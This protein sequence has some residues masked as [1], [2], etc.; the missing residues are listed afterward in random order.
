MKKNLGQV[1]TDKWL[2]N[3]IL[4]F[5]G[6][7]DNH[8]LDKKIIEPSCGDGAFLLEIVK[9]YIDSALSKNWSIQQIKEGLENHIYA[10]EIDKKYYKE[11]ILKLNKLLEKYQIT[12]VKWNI[13]NE[14]ALKIHQ[15]NG[16]MDFV[17]G[18]PPYVRVHNLD[19]EVR[20]YI[21]D[22]YKLCNNG[23]IDLY[24][25]FYELG[26]NMLNERGKLCYIT[27]NSFMYNNSFSIFREH[28]RKEQFLSKLINFGS[29]KVFNVSTYTA[30]MLLDKTHK[31]NLFDY[32]CYENKCIQFIETLNIDN[33]K[34]KIWSFSSN[35]NMYFVNSVTNKE[36]NI[37]SIATVQYGF[38]TLRDKIYISNNIKD[39][40]E[41]ICCFNGYPVEKELLKPIV[42]GSTY[43]GGNITEYILFPY[44]EGE[45]GK[46]KPI[47]EEEMMNFYPNAYSYFLIYKEELLKRDMDKNYEVWYQFGRSQGLQNMNKEKL[48]VKNI[49]KKE[50]GQVEVYKLPKDVF[51]YSGIFITGEEIDYVSELL[52]SEDFYRYVTI[53][54]KD[55]SGGYKSIST[56]IIKEYAIN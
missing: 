47:S 11:A 4:D 43:D 53:V 24:I 35:D 7:T 45:D 8:I 9:R 12:G 38:A 30:I 44:K 36:N 34:N 1:F 18:N 54:G 55:L 20:N 22:N 13:L 31:S 23:I 49:V 29:E 40:N 10:I 16:Q 3:L 6:Y 46:Y 37:K 15:Y 26:L 21:K 25:A 41:E 2:V 32:Y 19:I 33:F 28:I 14:D 52:Q 48:V 50:N 17:I 39:L 51:V 42:K 5:S 56:K 27:P